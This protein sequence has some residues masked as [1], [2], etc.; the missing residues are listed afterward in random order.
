MFPKN[1]SSQQNYW[2]NMNNKKHENSAHHFAENYP[3]NHVVKFMQG[4][5]KL[6]RFGALRANTG[7]QFF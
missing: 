5:I 3:T 6:W 7:H 4:C 2:Q 1:C